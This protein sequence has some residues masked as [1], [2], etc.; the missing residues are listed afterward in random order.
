MWR[1]YRLLV[2]NL[3]LGVLLGAGAWLG[4]FRVASSRG[5]CGVSM[6]T[7][8]K[9]RFNNYLTFGVTLAILLFFVITW[10]S[11]RPG[12]AFYSVGSTLVM[13]GLPFLFTYRTLKLR[14]LLDVCRGEGYPRRVP[15]LILLFSW[16]AIIAGGFAIFHSISLWPVI[17]E[18]SD[19]YP[20]ASRLRVAVFA[21]IVLWL[22]F[23]LL[24]T[25]F[26]YIRTECSKRGMTFSLRRAY[27]THLVFLALLWA[28]W[29]LSILLFGA[30]CLGVP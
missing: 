8:Q 17:G 3:A 4:A 18:R 26:R 5:G 9:F 20:E 6:I 24:L 30:A 28:V 2:S 16:L 14:E 19:F 21:S 25:H 10:G 11:I 13:G 1:V 7:I 22:T 29:P 23:L 15:K 27:K 12:I